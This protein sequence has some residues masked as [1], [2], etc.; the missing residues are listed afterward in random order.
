MAVVL[1]FASTNSNRAC[2]QAESA[3]SQIRVAPAI[4]VVTNRTLDGTQFWSDHFVHGDWRIQQHIHIQRCRLLDPADVRRAH[5]TFDTCLQTFQQLR[6]GGQTV[7]PAPHVVLVLHGLGRSRKSMDGM[8]GYLRENSEYRVLSVSYAST[9]A[10]IGVHAASLANVIKSLEGVEEISFV[11]HSMGNLVIRHYLA[12]VMSDESRREELAR[13]RRIVMLAPPNQGA[14]LADRFLRNP[15]VCA[16]WGVSG[17]EIANWQELAPRLAGAVRSVGII[18]G[19]TGRSLGRNPLIPGD[20]DFVVAVSETRLPG[21]QDF[22]VLPTLHAVIMDH[23]RV[24]EYT[25]RF[26]EY[27]FFVSE[28]ART[29]VLAVE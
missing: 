29:P 3:P 7:A 28:S 14:A 21:A 1:L 23:P 24:Q 12:D 22:V 19:G 2:D 4:P 11:A 13:V 8:V 6:E 27:G 15:I 26:L 5:G 20:D 17:G 18:A 9:R 16:V 25:M 10:E